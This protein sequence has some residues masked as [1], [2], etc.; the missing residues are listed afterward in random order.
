MN[1]EFL[2]K[3]KE[4]LEIPITALSDEHL[5]NII[6]YI[7]RKAKIGIMIGY[8]GGGGDVDNMW[9][10][11]I[12]LYGKKVKKHLHYKIYKNELKRREIL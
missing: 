9:Y 12:E 5:K 10:D 7:K 6:A 8:G 2:H 4:G 1:K 3:T 11:E